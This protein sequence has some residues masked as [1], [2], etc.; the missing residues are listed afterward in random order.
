MGCVPGPGGADQVYPSL[1]SPA[2]CAVCAVRK[3][4]THVSHWRT[5]LTSYGAIVVGV[6][7]LDVTP[8]PRES[9]PPQCQ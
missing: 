5:Q 3:A 9:R 6:F 2:V 8:P 1:H 4:G 7:P